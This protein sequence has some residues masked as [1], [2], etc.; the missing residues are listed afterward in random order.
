MSPGCK[1]THLWQP[2]LSWPG[3]RCGRAS[4]FPPLTLPG[5]S[6][7]FRQLSRLC[8]HLLWQVKICL[9][10]VP[11][12]IWGRQGPSCAHLESLPGCNQKFPRFLFSWGG[13]DV[14]EGGQSKLGRCGQQQKGQEARPPQVALRGPPPELGLEALR[15]GG[16]AGSM[17]QLGARGGDAPFP[18]ETAGNVSLQRVS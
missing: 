14:G 2:E 16:P 7:H 5:P 17:G 12:G 11:P 3:E 9:L 13:A 8:Q 4:P 18:W 15:G 6:V 1:Q 10:P